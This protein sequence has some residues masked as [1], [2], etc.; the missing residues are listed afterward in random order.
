MIISLGDI[1]L[2]S[3]KKVAIFLK[4]HVMIN[5]SAQVAVGIFR[6]KWQYCS[7]IFR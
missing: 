5:F 3:A 7:K 2:F 6:Q 4:K 1:D